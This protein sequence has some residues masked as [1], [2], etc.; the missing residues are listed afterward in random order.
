MTSSE[1][2]VDPKASVEAVELKPDQVQT[3]AILQKQ[4]ETLQDQVIDWDVALQDIE[5]QMKKDYD[6]HDRKFALLKLQVLELREQLSDKDNQLRAKD[7]YI[8]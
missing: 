5:L 4:N 3:I 8:Q 6:M 2:E 1:A 7:Q